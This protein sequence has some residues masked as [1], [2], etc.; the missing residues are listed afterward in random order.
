MMLADLAR[1]QR[2][3]G[4]GHSASEVLDRIRQGFD[5]EWASPTEVHE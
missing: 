2:V 3:R 1:H 5:A 4:Q